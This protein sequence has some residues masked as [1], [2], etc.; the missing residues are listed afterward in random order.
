MRPN[1]NDTYLAITLNDYG[2][3]AFC[4]GFY[5]LYAGTGAVIRDF[6]DRLSKQERAG[7]YE[8]GLADAYRRYQAGEREAKADNAR[9]FYPLTLCHTAHVEQRD[10]SMDFV[11]VWGF[12]YLLRA[13]GVETD[14]LYVEMEGQYCRFVSA[15]FQALACYNDICQEYQPF[16]PP[17][18]WG[19]PCVLGLDGD[20]VYSYLAYFEREFASL[21]EMEADIKEPAPID[22]SDFFFDIFGDG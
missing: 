4:S 8:A 1:T 5:R 12:S 14:I 15:S 7:R 18:F 6:L 9:A 21:D 16:N 22:Y 2:C 20:R 3:P 17:W 11:N 10:W 19:H 13:D